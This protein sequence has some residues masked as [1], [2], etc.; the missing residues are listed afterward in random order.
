[1]C[2]AIP[3]FD[4]NMVLPPFVG[5]SAARPDIQSPYLCSA[6]A[7]LSRFGTTPERREL[8]DKFLKF[9]RGIQE[10]GLTTGFQWL[11]GSFLEDV[12]TKEGRPPKDIDVVTVFWGYD[13]AALQA[14][15]TKFPAF[16]DANKAKADYT[17]D[18]YLLD[19]SAPIETVLLR[20]CYWFRLLSHNRKGVQKGILQ[21]S[22]SES[23]GA[24]VPL[25]NTQQEQS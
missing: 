13:I 18:H 15:A 16:F 17:V 12:E 9:R 14:I 11:D 22:L 2:C 21:I 5:E 20:A 6:S 19:A 3:E 8:I 24:A 1:V 4:A 25:E 7:L 23:A 10:A